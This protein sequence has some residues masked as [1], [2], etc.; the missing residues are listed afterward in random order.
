MLSALERMTSAQRGIM[1]IVI[2]VMRF[3]IVLPRMAT[4]ARARMM[5]GKAIKISM[6][7]WRY[8]STLPPK[9]ALPTPRMAPSVEPT[10]AAP[11]PTMRAV[12]EP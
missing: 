9:N 1:G 6:K 2:A 8:R 3:G 7:R 10:T 12:R 4:M 5:S 11:K